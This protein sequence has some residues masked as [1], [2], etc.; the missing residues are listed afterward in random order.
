MADPELAIGIRRVQGMK[1]LGQRSG[2]WLTRN[3]AQELVN[4]ACN[5]DLRGWRDGASPFPVGDGRFAW[6]MI[7]AAVSEGLASPCK[8]FIFF[9]SWGLNLPPHS[10]QLTRP[11]LTTG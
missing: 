5:T 4:A 9:R 1:R 8:A 3:E 2:N 10:L 11:S 6:P 7:D